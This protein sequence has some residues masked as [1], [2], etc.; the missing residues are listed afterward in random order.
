[1]SSPASV[2]VSSMLRRVLDGSLEHRR[3]HV[4]HVIK[5]HSA[6][7]DDVGKSIEAFPDWAELALRSHTGD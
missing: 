5:E 7:N 1:M 6:G 3:D 2:G 4:W